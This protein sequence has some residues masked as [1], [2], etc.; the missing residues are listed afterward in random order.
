MENQSQLQ[1]IFTTRRETGPSVTLNE[2]RIPQA[3]KTKYLEIYRSQTKLEKTHIY[4]N[5]HE[6]LG[7]QLRKMY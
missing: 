1:V 3:D 4:A 2:Q 5:K 7:L 6:Q